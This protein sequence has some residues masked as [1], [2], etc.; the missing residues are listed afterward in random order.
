MPTFYLVF[1]TFCG[2]INYG[3]DE[4]MD[5]VGIY[6][7]LDEANAAVDKYNK[8]PEP[9]APNFYL[10]NRLYLGDI[11]V[12]I[13]FMLTGA[14]L[15]LS[16]KDWRGCTEFYKKRFLAIFPSFWLVY[17]IVFLIKTHFKYLKICQ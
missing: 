1:V 17:I 5:L 14:S 11:G 3:I 13:F 7:N 2:D 9:F 15:M 6:S 4:E 10:E 8:S 16:T 12:S